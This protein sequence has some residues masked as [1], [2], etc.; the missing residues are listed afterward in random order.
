MLRD[1]CGAH[2]GRVASARSDDV[3]AVSTSCLAAN[4]AAPIFGLPIGRR[5]G[6]VDRKFADGRA[7][8]GLPAEARGTIVCNVEL[9]GR[10]RPRARPAARAGGG[11]RHPP[12]SLLPL[13]RPRTR[14]RAAPRPTRA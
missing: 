11:P 2:I 4:G 3:V 10:A 1:A 9:A 6:V 8:L 13:T 7:F 14:S 12:P 5:R